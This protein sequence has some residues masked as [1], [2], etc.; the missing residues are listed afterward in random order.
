MENIPTPEDFLWNHIC[1]HEGTINRWSS[2]FGDS[3]VLIKIFEKNE[4]VGNSLIIDFLITVGLS[5]NNKFDPVEVQNKSLSGLGIKVFNEINKQMP[6]YIEGEL[7]RERS[8]ILS[9]FEEYF[10]EGQRY[11]P[12]QEIIDAYD[13]AYKDLNERVRLKFFPEKEKLF[14]KETRYRKSTDIDDKDV[15]VIANIFLQLWRRSNGSF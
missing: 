5:N 15:R 13:L 4:F 2:I 11:C 12:N 8:D 10:T 3:S 9:Y 1:D 7:N 6:L 14:N